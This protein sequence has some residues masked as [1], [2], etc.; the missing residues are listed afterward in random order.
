VLFN[1]GKNVFGVDVRE[2]W[3]GVLLKKRIGHKQR[4][5]ERYI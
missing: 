2:R 1:G 4:L 5:R 3:Q